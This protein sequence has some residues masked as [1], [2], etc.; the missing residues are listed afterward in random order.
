MLPRRSF[1]KLGAGATAAAFLA[2]PAL[3]AA[4]ESQ[5]SVPLA[6]FA[7]VGDTHYFA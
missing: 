6:A 4:E 7:V 5:P 3:L 1:L 2:R